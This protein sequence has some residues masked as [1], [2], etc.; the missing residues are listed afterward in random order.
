MK[1]EK[2]RAHQHICWIPFPCA[3]GYATGLFCIRPSRGAGYVIKLCYDGSPHTFRVKRVSAAL[4]S[5]VGAHAHDRCRA[6]LCRTQTESQE[7]QL[8]LD[9]RCGFESLAAL[10]SYYGPGK[11][12]PPGTQRSVVAGR[13]LPAAWTAQRARAAAAYPYPLAARLSSTCLTPPA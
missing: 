8:T 13:S 2:E 11:W 10:V 12:T 1:R 7:Q 5:S 4:A 9:G 6:V 3:Q